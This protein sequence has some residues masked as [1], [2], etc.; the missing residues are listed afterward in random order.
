MKKIGI[1]A[2]MRG[3]LHPL[4]REWPRTDHVSIGELRVSHGGMAHGTASYPAS[5][6]VQCFA[7]AEGIGA[8]AATRSFAAL[9][10][11]A[12]QLDA[13]VSYGWAGALSCGAKPPSVY[14]VAEVVDAQTGERFLADTQAFGPTSA[15]RLV[16]LDHVAA[17][18]EKRALAERYQAVLVD[19][20]AA[21]VA[22]LARAHGI[23]FLCLRGISDG[24]AD[25]LP[26]FNRFIT[27]QG[28]LRTAAFAA[29]ALLRPG[30]WGPLM[31]L[32][33]NSR[34]A[35]EALARALPDVLRQTKLV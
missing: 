12:G 8:A 19:M 33:R 11:A 16:T 6:S 21:T 17:Q 15:L 23:P 25:D 9:R 13:I 14:S 2:A 28:Q 10:A 27:P 26:D 5:Y 31:E 22:R 24:Y 35:A 4:V 3:E 32:G 34:A 29:S 7:S 30:S 1:V 20:E 18:G